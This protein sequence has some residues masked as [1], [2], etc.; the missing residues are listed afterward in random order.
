VIPAF[1]ITRFGPVGAKLIFFGSIVLAVLLMG[2]LLYTVGRSDGK[3]GEVVDQL[4]R[5]VEVQRGIGTADNVSA[6]SRVRDAVRTE[7]Q[8]KELSDA[9]E[10][11]EDPDRRRA[12]RGC[13][14]L[15]QQGRDTSGI[16]AC[17]GPPGRP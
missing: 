7:Q 3:R 16:P 9:L 4:E 11:T 1:L 13:V 14:I 5:E 12:L 17:S 6:E 8:K 15:R 10:A 2:V